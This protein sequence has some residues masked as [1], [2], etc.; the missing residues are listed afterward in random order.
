MAMAVLVFVAMTARPA[1]D[2]WIIREDGVG[3]VKVGMTLPQLNSVLREK[4]SAPEDKD[5]KKCFYVEPSAHPQLGFM[6]EN[7]YLTRIDVDGP[8]V[9]TSKGVQVGD[10][11]DRARRV[12]GP[13]MVVEP[14]AYNPEEGHYLIILSKD[15]RYGIRFETEKGKIIKFYEIEPSSAAAL[16]VR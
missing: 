10:S 12:Y 11:E 14:H 6:I 5:E 8:G 9:L 13:K 2:R 7:G 3:P 16:L 15:G 4:F 1:K